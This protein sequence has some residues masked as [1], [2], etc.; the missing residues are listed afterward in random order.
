MACPKR[1]RKRRTSAQIGSALRTLGEFAAGH[2]IQIRLEVHGT[3][4]SLLP[5]IKTII[6]AANH[7]AVGVCWNSNPS[8][9]EGEGFDHNFDLVKQKITA[10]HMRDL[11]LEDYPFRKLL[12]SL[13][14]AGYRGYCL[15]E[16]PP[17]SDPVRVMKY[18][19]AL[20]LAYQDLL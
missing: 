4:T 14:A 3:G 7:P 13:A 16:I 11:C 9:L 1:C 18:Y 5:N 10:V 2:G 6:D 8:D 12:Q 15:A 19:R 17:S 20:W